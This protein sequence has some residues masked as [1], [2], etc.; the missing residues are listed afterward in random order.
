MKYISR[1]V[2]LD[3]ADSTIDTSDNIDYIREAVE[4]AKCNLLSRHGI[5][6]EPPI[7]TEFNRVVIEVK[8]PEDKIENFSI[9]KRLKGIPGYL[10]RTYPEKFHK[11]N[12]R[13]FFYREFDTIRKDKDGKI[14]LGVRTNAMSKFANLLNRD[15]E[16]SINKIMK[17]LAILK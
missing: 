10:L 15:D 6:L 11:Q 12:N 16:E 8:V 3:F 9:G 14:S 5:L 13:V 7:I 1:F 2:Q 4:F 17:I